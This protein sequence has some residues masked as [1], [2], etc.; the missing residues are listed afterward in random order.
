MEQKIDTE[1]QTQGPQIK[2]GRGV[3]AVFPRFLP[4][5]VNGSIFS[6]QNW[7]NTLKI[8][9][10]VIFQICILNYDNI[11][12]GVPYA[13][14]NRAA[15]ALIG[16]REDLRPDFQRFTEF[17]HPFLNDFRS[18]VCGS[19]IYDNDFFAD[20]G[21]G[22]LSN[23]FQKFIKRSFLIE[24]RNN[25]RENF[26]FRKKIFFLL[27]FLSRQQF[28]GRLHR[29]TA[30]ACRFFCSREN[31]RIFSRNVH[32]QQFFPE[33]LQKRRRRGKPVPVP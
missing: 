32:V 14:P 28:R 33:W 4:G 16:L 15:F 31:S 2:N 20:I 5:S 11:S 30:G 17:F 9:L 22:G 1:C 7:F 27:S 26:F 23:L 6:L 12:M 21:Q 25:D 10:R 8:I 18:P 29:G 19:V 13:C 24:D 3:K